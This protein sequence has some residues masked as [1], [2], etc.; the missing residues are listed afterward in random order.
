MTRALKTIILI[1][2]TTAIVSVSFLAWFAERGRDCGPDEEAVAYARSLSD[3]RLAK[4]YQDMKKYYK[5]SPKSTVIYTKLA[6]FED[7]EIVS[8]RPW[9]SSITVEGCFDDYVHMNFR[10][11]DGNQDPEISLSCGERKNLCSGIVLW[12]RH[13][14]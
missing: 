4:L 12:P 14:T 1:A 8:V 3:E 7:L 2:G 5:E 11:L 10:G 9:V 13:A 6:E